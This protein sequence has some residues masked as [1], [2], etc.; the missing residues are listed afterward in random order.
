MPGRRTPLALLCAIIALLGLPAIASADPLSGSSLGG[1]SGAMAVG[2]SDEV[3]PVGNGDPEITPPTNTTPMAVQPW[4]TSDYAVIVSGTDGE[5]GVD[6]IEYCV[7]NGSVQYVNDGDLATV[8]AGSGIYTLDTRVV[9]MAGNDSG[10]RHET[11]NV[12]VGKPTDITDPG[13][14]AWRNTATSVDVMGADAMSGLDHLE[15][16][17]DGGVIQVGGAGVNPLNVPISADGA[18]TLETRAVD[19]AGN[20]SNWR[21]HTIR[22]DT[23][24]PTD[25]TAAPGGWQT[26]PY[27][28]NVT[29]SDAHSGIAQVSY[30]VDNGSVVTSGLPATVLVSADGIHTV[31]TRVQDVAGNW[32]GWK[33]T[34]VVRIDTTAPDNQT[35]AAPTGWIATD[36]SVPVRGA[37]DGSGVAEVRWRVDNGAITAGPTGFTQA[38]VTGT[39]PHTLETMVV[40]VAGNGVWRSESVNIDKVAPTNTTTVPSGPVPNPLSVSVTGTD[41]HSGV[42]HV[43]WKVDNGSFQTGASG[44]TAAIAGNGA[45]TLVT[46]IYDMAGNVTERTDTITIDISLNNDTTAPTDTT[47]VALTGWSADPVTVHIRATDAGV[48][49]DAV[50][51]RLPGKPIETRSGDHFDLTFTE[52]GVYKLETRGRDLAG[53]V[54]AWNLQIV[55]LDFTV[56]ADTTDIPATWVASRTFNW[57]ATDALS[58]PATFQ[59]MIDNGP[60][61]TAAVGVPITVPSDGTFQIDHRVL[62]AAGQSSEWSVHT[63]KVDSVAP[64]NTTGPVNSSWSPTALSLP[65]SGTDATSGLDKMQW[66]LNGGDIQDGGP[67]VV[68]QDGEYTLETRALDVAGNDSG[69]RS[70]TVRIDVTDPVNDTPAAPAGWRKTDY[71]VHVAGSDGAGSGIAGVEVKVDGGAVTTSPDVTITGDGEHTLETRVI[72]NVGHASGWRSETIKIDTALPTA[73][74]T[75]PAGWNAR[76]VSCTVGANGG[77]SG[78]G[79]I[80]ASRDGGAYAA[81]TGTAVPVSTDGDHTIVVKVA[82]GAGNEKTATAHVKVD[83]TLPVAALSCAAATTPTGYTCHATGS[84]ALSGLASLSYS[85]NGG[86]WTT[87][88]T[89]GA[90]AALKGTLR[91]RAIDTAGNQG[92][93]SL[94]TLVD[95][96]KPPAPKPTATMRVKSVPVYLGGKTD[97]DSMIGAFKAARSANGTVSVDLRPLAVGRGTYKVQVVIK[98]GKRK[99]TVTKTSKVGRG[100]ALRRMGGSLS[101]AAAKTTVTLT[102]LKK[103]GHGWRRYAT[104][105]IVLAK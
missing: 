30:Q 68:D 54:S 74:L 67:A 6:H 47:P 5:S 105:K 98:S 85:L 70:D 34:T 3:P 37:D 88:P 101:G 86:A 60:L 104:A 75:C 65:L 19:V 20:I 26:A 31:K 56:P 51:W 103:S 71:T 46:R 89:G 57:S 55:R 78:I 11:I 1:F 8:S 18:H 72:D 84:D 100:G 28:V 24:T 91:I 38:T 69:W 40:D 96:A 16:R 81:V 95:R 14:V 93:S 35:P 21:S 2:C 9:D 94:V 25:D 44:D 66:R 43:Q 62:D 102:V 49:M 29:G 61:Q 41:A 22:V 73:T 92:L 77:L 45:H 99:R 17:L 90:L 63:L 82:D 32:S 15:W 50:Q 80:T 12:D 76:A 52:E 36:Y 58:G 79:A 10:W 83:R 13:T 64:S 4:Y 39:G 27:T 97:D 33:S 7:N 48:G 42:D 87:V 23:V 53:N 59:Y